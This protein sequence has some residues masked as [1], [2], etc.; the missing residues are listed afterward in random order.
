MASYAWPSKSTLSHGRR[1]TAY[2]LMKTFQRRTTPASALT[3]HGVL[4]GCSAAK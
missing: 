3:G 4:P 1:F 2:S